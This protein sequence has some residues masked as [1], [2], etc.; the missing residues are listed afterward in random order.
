MPAVV[1]YEPTVVPVMAEDE[2]ASLMAMVEQRTG[3]A[4]DGWLTDAAQAFHAWLS[5][6]HEIAGLL[7]RGQRT[8]SGTVYADSEQHVAQHVAG[9]RVREALPDLG[10]WAP[11]LAPEAVADELVASFDSIPQPA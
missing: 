11:T 2:H 9:P 10:P 7:L 1:V 3:A 4:G 5:R 6:D 8:R